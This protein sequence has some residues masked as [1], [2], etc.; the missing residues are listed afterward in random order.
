VL[1]ISGSKSVAMDTEESFGI[2]QWALVSFM[3]GILAISTAL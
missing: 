1:V 3:F 2:A